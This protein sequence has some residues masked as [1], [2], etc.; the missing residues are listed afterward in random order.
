MI[1]IEN[2]LQGAIDQPKQMNTDAKDLKN[3]VSESYFLIY[4]PIFSD[5]S[6]EQSIS[7]DQ[8]STLIID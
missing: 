1:S 4:L 3:Y 2:K 8:F 7:E 6:S 5:N